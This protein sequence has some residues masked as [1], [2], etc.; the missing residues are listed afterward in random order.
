MNP[1]IGG[2]I[3]L[4]SEMFLA[5]MLIAKGYGIR[6]CTKILFITW[7]VDLTWI[8]PVLPVGFWSINSFIGCKTGSGFKELLTTFQWAFR[9]CL[10]CK[11]INITYHSFPWMITMIRGYAIFLAMSFACMICHIWLSIAYEL[12]RDWIP[13][14]CSQLNLGNQIW[15]LTP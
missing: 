15:N 11:V 8:V 13:D 7:A 10:T 9:I 2:V 3:N 4:K 14:P 12:Y 1:F 5:T 6:W